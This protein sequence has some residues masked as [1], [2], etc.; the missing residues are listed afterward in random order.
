MKIGMF[1]DSYRPYTSGVV[2]SLETFKDELKVMGHEVNIFAPNYPNCEK[3]PDVHRFFSIPAP[4]NKDFTLA[5]PFS[6]GMLSKLKKLNLDI[7]HVH[8]P[9]LLGRL[10]ARYA[11]KLGIPLV[12]TYHTL[13][14]KYVHYVPIGQNVTKEITQKFAN[15]FCNQCD[16]VIVP[17]NVIVQRLK[18]Q[19]VV[20]PV[21]AVPTGIYTK[22][23]RTADK[24]WLSNKYNISKDKKIMLFVGRIGQEKNIE[25]LLNSFIKTNQADQDTVLVLVGSGPEEEKIRQKVKIYNLQQNVIFTGTLPKPEVVKAYAGADLFVFA[26]VTET[27]GLVIAEAKAAGLPVVAV[28]AYGVSE[29]VENGE[30]GFLCPLDINVFSNAVLKILND[31]NLRDLMGQNALENA[32]KLSSR[33]C[34]RK[35]LSVYERLIYSDHRKGDRLHG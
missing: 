29:M 35:L 34:A 19:G 13:Y 26:S 14:D 28:D 15:D 23:F 9:F 30:D 25:F 7:I 27:Q 33:N 24:D 5:I 20:V 18:K 17:T 2:R 1:S 6:V 12:F 31:S 8:S 32:E 11:R 10:G 16:Q 4:T 22:E 3:E 21:E